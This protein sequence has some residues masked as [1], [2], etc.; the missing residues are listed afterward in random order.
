MQNAE[1]QMAYFNLPPLTLEQSNSMCELTLIL[2]DLVKFLTLGH[3][4]AQRLLSLLA[5]LYVLCRFY[6]NVKN[7]KHENYEKFTKTKLPIEDKKTT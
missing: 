2:S 3:K 1:S 4:A 6:L 5:K 7:Y